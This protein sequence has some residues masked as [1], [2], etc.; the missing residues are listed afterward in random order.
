MNKMLKSKKRG[1]AIPLAAVAVL[2]LLAMG[3][4]LLSLGLTPTR[5][6]IHGEPLLSFPSKTFYTICMHLQGRLLPLF[7]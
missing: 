5:G 6:V 4:G 2:I 7:C 3:T 1:S